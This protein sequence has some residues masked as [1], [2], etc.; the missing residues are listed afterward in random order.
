MDRISELEARIAA[1]TAELERLKAETDLERYGLTASSACPICGRDKPHRHH[2]GD[3]LV[4]HPGI[5]RARLEKFVST[6]LD[7]DFYVGADMFWLEQAGYHDKGLQ[8]EW[9]RVS[10]LRAS[11]SPYGALACDLRALLACHDKALAARNHDPDVVA[12]V[13]WARSAHEAYSNTT[14]WATLDRALAPFAA[15]KGD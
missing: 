11:W 2:G 14:G 4:R 5:I 3:V 15:I 10:K 8:N 12:L 9:S 6:A 7:T 13:E 1:D